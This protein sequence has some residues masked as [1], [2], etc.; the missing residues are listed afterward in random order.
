MATADS[1]T[2]HTSRARADVPRLWAARS[3]LFL[4]GLVA[5]VISA[6]GG[7][8]PYFGPTFGYSADGS[9]SWHWNLAHT[10]LA[11][12]PAIVGIFAGVL[13]LARAPG[14]VQRSSRFGLGLAGL[15]ALAAGGWF[16]VGPWAWQLTLGSSS[17]LVHATS[18]RTLANLLGY[19]FG[20][21]LILA[22]SGAF[23]LGWVVRHQRPLEAVPAVTGPVASE[24]VPSPPVR[25]TGV[26]P[27]VPP[28][29]ETPPESTN[30]PSGT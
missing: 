23:A 5:L 4:V 6:W 27:P 29:F 19:S 14:T 28:S 26:A 22:A 9:G 16:V 15:L 11:F 7:I 10:V 8:I 13:I 24:Q 30:I 2:Q 3:S 1:T 18:L 25:E 12:S 21:G 20:P 17:Y